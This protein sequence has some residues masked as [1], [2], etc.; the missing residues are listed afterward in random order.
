MKKNYISLEK[1]FDKQ[2]KI[3]KRKIN[4]N[5]EECMINDSDDSFKEC[6]D[7]TWLKPEDKGKKWDKNTFK[8]RKGSLK[9]EIV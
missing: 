7:D 4:K 9:K 8:L 3:I 5:F 1:A 2:K 6:L